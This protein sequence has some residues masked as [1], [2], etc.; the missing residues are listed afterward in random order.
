MSEHPATPASDGAASAPARRKVLAGATL[1]NM[2]SL[3]PAVHSVFGLFLIPLSESFG[4]PRAAIS[5]ALGIVAVVSA[6]LYPLV[7]RY[8]D[9]REIWPMLVVGNVGFAGAL[10]LLSVLNGSLAQFYLIYFLIAMFGALP[11]PAVLNKLVIGAYGRRFGV[12]VGISGGGGNGLGATL[13]PVLG[14]LLL[15][16]YGWRT[17]YLGVAAM[18]VALGLPAILFLLREKSAP[19]AS[20][21]VAAGEDPPVALGAVARTP[22][23]WLIMAAFPVMAGVMTAIFGHIVPIAAERGLGVAAPTAAIGACAL[24]NAVGQPAIGW[25]F[26]RFPTPRVLLAPYLG[27]FVGI[28]LLATAMSTPLLTL[29]GILFGIG[30][31]TQFAALPILLSRYFGTS[32]FGVIFGVMYSGMFLAQGLSPIGLDAVFDWQGSYHSALTVIEGVVLVGMGL[33]AL[34]PPVGSPTRSPNL[35]LAHAADVD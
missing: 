7:G 30:I 26:D 14:A 31:A 1:G 8:A 12:A 19:S 35:Q 15:A 27:S 28:V 5:G 25:L 13:M 11:N 20:P 32:N 22:V 2:V 18:V 6:L 9:R 33:I 21:A 4:W 24:I 10:G 17:A 29:G 34:L 23:F 3:T 16:A